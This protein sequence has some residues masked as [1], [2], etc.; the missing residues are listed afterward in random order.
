MKKKKRGFTLV[1]LLAV[2][3][4]LAV[5]L[6]IAVPRIMSV[7][8]D[9][10]LGSIESTAKIIASTAESRY[11]SKKALGLEVGT[12]KC[13]DV[14]SLSNDYGTCK[15]T[16]DDNGVATVIVN[17]KKDG[18]FNNLACQGTKDNMTC[19]EGEISTARKCTTT[20]TLTN[21]LKFVDGQYTYRYY[22]NLKGW[23]VILTD[24]TSTEPVTTELCG[25]INDK[26]IVSMN[27]MFWNSKAE[28][29]DLSSFDTSK[30]TDMNSMFRESVATEINGLENFDTSSVTDMSQMFYK[31]QATSLDLS[32]FDTS[33]VTSMSWMFHNSAAT[34]IK[35][36]ENFNTSKVTD[37]SYMFSN[38]K[39]TTLDLSSFDTSNVTSMVSMFSSSQATTLDVSSF[40]TSN[41]TN[42]SNMFSGSFFNQ[43]AATEIKGLENFNTS[44]VTNMSNMFS[45]SKVTT[46]DLSNFNT[47]NVTNMASMFAGTNVASLD[48][49]NFDTSKVT[50]MASMF[51]DTKVTSLDL[52]SFDT[53]KVTN[54]KYMFYNS[55]A[56]SLDLSSFD[57]SSV[58]DMNSMFSSSAATT[59][60]AR[61][62]SDADRFNASS[63][64]PSA[65]TFVVKS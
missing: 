34:E 18:K 57:T 49:S 11:E 44:K 33:N 37:M 50:N 35:G 46:L 21:D 6:V 42:M 60:Y 17:G 12:L 45:Y 16:F 27:N 36:L 24:K 64:K 48:L 2:I 14:A 7:I 65:L 20:D 22:L 53:S 13:T 26:P 55:K 10:K 51:A 28:S 23:I 5:I 38:T 39:A 19:A 8:K 47:S 9:A 30:V 58:T 31:S 15:I 56:T 25:T 52:S 43:M 63:S 40:D 4:I 29:I 59:G 54:M 1:E 61:T 41:V 62:Q 32:S 3:V